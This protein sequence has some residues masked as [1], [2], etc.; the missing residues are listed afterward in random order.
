[1]SDDYKDDL[2]CEIKSVCNKEGCISIAFQRQ[3]NEDWKCF[4]VR[5][6]VVE[7]HV[8]YTEWVVTQG[9]SWDTITEAENYLRSIG[10]YVP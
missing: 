10:Y 3:V 7:K 6:N 8:V 1:M 9:M 5:T 4:V 2:P